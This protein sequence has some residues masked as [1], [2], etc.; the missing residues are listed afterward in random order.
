[1]RACINKD[2]RVP[3]ITAHYADI[4]KKS[5]VDNA[6]HEAL[7]KHDKITNLIICAGYCQN[8]DAVNM[9][10][11]QVKAMLGVNLEGAFFTATAYARYLM[12]RKMPGNIIFIGSISGSIVNVPQ[13]QAMY[14][15]SKAAIRHLAASLAVEWARQG[16]RVNCLSPG[17]MITEQAMYVTV[18]AQLHI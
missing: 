14:N 3:K 9:T 10:A 11:E 16:I 8:I 4:A 1:M 12:A 7:S 17:Y 2:L 15:S 5:D 6:I 18:Q 13:P